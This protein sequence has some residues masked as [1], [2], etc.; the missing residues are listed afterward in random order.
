M[1]SFSKDSGYSETDSLSPI[2]LTFVFLA[3]ESN[4]AYRAFFEMKKHG[5]K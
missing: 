1:Q 3:A 2:Q 5:S 4:N